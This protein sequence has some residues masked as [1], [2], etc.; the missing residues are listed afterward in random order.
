MAGIEQLSIW[1][2]AAIL[3]SPGMAAIDPVD[4]ADTARQPVRQSTAAAL[5]PGGERGRPDTAS[6]ERP[7]AVRVTGEAFPYEVSAAVSVPGVV[8]ASASASVAGPRPVS[9]GVRVSVEVL[10]HC[11]PPP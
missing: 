9:V 4:T 3:S 10:R 2:I 6:P 11:P 7:E 1:G 5:S 8:C